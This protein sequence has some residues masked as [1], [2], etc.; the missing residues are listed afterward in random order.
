MAASL[1]VALWFFAPVLAD[2]WRT[3]PVAVRPDGSP[4]QPIGAL[5][6]A[7]V[8][9][10]VARNARVLTTAPW[11]VFD[12][13]LCYPMPRA[14]TLGEHMLGTAV[15]AAPAYAIARDPVLAYDAAVVLGLW[16]AA[17]AMYALAFHFTGSPPASFAAG[18]AFG[19]V[20][21]RIADPAH[22][23]AHG[24]LWTPLVLLFWARLLEQGRW[25]D[26]IG[27]GAFL[28]LQL[29]ESF[30]SVVECALVVSVVG[31]WAAWRHR[32][33]LGA[34]LP[35]MAVAAAIVAS[36]AVALFGPYLATRATWGLLAERTSFL[37]WPQ[38]FGPGGTLYSGTVAVALAA[39]ALVDRVVGGA[40]D[41]PGAARGARPESPRGDPRWAMAAAG[42][43]AFW[44]SCG[45]I[46]LP[47]L[48]VALPAPAFALRGIVPGLDAVRALSLVGLGASLAIA[49]VSAYGVLA[50]G[51]R[52]GGAG[53]LA[54]GIV[55]AFATFGERAHA[56]VARA[57]FG[58]P[59]DV[60]ASPVRPPDDVVALVERSVSGPTVDLPVPQKRLGVLR[61]LS[62]QILIAAYHRQPTASCYNSFNGPVSAQV[63]ELAARLPDPGAAAALSA[64]GFR[65]AI[66]F[67][68][69]LR[70]AE[71]AALSPPARTPEDGSASAS[72]PAMSLVGET[73]D[74]AVYA[75]RA[76]D[77]SDDWAVLGE[78]SR[79]ERSG[80]PRHAVAGERVEISLA[81]RNGG[82]SP[83][84]HPSP[85][86]PTDLVLL[87]RPVSSPSGTPAAAPLEQSARTLL[88]LALAPGEAASV[89][90]AATAP[91]EP[92]DYEVVVSRAAARDRVLG[93]ARAVVSARIAQPAATP[94]S[95]W[96]AGL[97]RPP[98]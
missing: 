67:R 39:V 93:Q 10:V 95:A 8:V 76:V 20:S 64:L 25:R 79:D 46:E 12:G 17:L 50:I 41:D 62:D 89:A 53:V 23:Y 73:A 92:G 14:H 54:V 58:R 52:G 66:A 75:L 87:W 3:V 37:N 65:N 71:R 51:R 1:A 30:Y 47:W 36:V 94:S 61:A 24:D 5:D 15:L 19:L 11:R 72:P 59:F 56:G 44:V 34:I 86:A 83:F 91:D 43:L 55:A 29:L 85:I 97:P 69:H 74:V 2:P 48:G 40:R 82:A 90:I 18:L 7:M 28:T 80:A 63:Q 45:P 9:S 49:F 57:T 88:P 60:I 98:G 6:Q 21:V 70:P 84:R 81:V 26:A 68:R 38:A 42:A 78:D 16:I 22:P 32:E 35:Q 13:D 77:A 33:R 31:A 4:E 96:P 27:C